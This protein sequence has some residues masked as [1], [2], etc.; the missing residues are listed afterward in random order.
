LAPSRRVGEGDQ[1]LFADHQNAFPGV[2]EYRGIEGASRF[3]LPTQALQ[4]ASV[5]LLLEQCLNLGPQ[6]LRIERL[7]QIIHGA[8]GVAL[9]HGGL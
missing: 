8:R 7:E 6:N 5:A 2:F 3:Q 9:E 1:T 4:V